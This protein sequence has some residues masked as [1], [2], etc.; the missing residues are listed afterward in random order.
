MK[1]IIDMKRLITIFCTI[2]LALSCTACSGQSGA[3]STNPT[4]PSPSAV[5][6]SAGQ[7][8]VTEATKETQYPATVITWDAD[9]NEISQ[10][11]ESAPERVIANNLSS[12][13][14]LLRLGLG[15]KIIGMLNPDNQVTGE[16]ADQINAITWIGDKKTVS[17]E[18]IVDIEP[19]IIVGRVAMF[20]ESGMGTISDLNNEGINVYAQG[21]SITSQTRTLEDIFTDILNLGIIFNVQDEAEAYVNELMARRDAIFIGNEKDGLKN[22]VIICNYKDNSFGCYKSALQESMLNELGYTNVASSGSGFSLEDMVNMA[23]ELIIYVT[24][25]RNMEA[26]ANA[27][28]AIKGE[29]VLSEVPAV[30][31]GCIVEIGYDVLMDYGASIFDAME[32]ISGAVQ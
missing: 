13:E 14:I 20:S 30:V 23:P 17:K 2:A 8:K 19:D 1:G 24:S 11:F 25:D 16:Y 7:D 10:T 15:D 27:V 6:S 21:A 29:P 12:A 31:N 5:P 22:A 26:D 4:S 18:V 32:A 9:G 3:P 28:N